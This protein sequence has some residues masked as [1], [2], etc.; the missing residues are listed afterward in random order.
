VSAASAIA[1]RALFQTTQQ[2][3]RSLMTKTTTIVGLLTALMLGHGRT[4]SAQTTPAPLTQGYVSINAGAQPQT[5]TFTTSASYPIYGETATFSADH[6]VSNG[7]VFDIN[8]GKRVT[9]NLAIGAGFT[10]FSA[11]K[12]ASVV[13]SSVPSPLFFNQPQRTVQT[14]S[15]LKH[16]ERAFYVQ[17]VY[18]MPITSKIDIS[19]GIGPTFIKVN[20]DLV[21]NIDIPARTQA[22]VPIVETQSKTAVGV[23]VGFD[24]TYL[25]TPRIGAGL[26][27]RYA[28]AKTDLDSV[29]GLKVGGLQGGLGLR[30]RF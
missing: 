4:A 1:P 9:G 15:D 5:R 6:H 25:F 3:V 12:D 23:I 18:I 11:K 19:L 2:Y 22:A 30:V 10:S 26:F 16:T 7:P 24:G 13:T 29:S 20:Q 8:G 17:A 28:G 21:S 27:V 14:M